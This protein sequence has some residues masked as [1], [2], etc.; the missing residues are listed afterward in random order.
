MSIIGSLPFILT[1][2]QVA[3]ATQVMADFNTIIAEVNAGAVP[4]SALPLAVASGG[5]GT[6]TLT[7]NAVLLGN[8]VGVVQEVAAGTNGNLL[9]DN[10]TIWESTTALTGAY[11]FSGAIA[12]SAAIVS[13]STI[14]FSGNTAAPAGA[15]V[16]SPAANTLCLSTNAVDRLCIGP[17]GG[18]YLQGA[19]GGDAGAGSL[20][21]A[22]IFQNG[23][24]VDAVKARA[25]YNG[26]TA[27]LVGNLNI[28]SV[29]KNATGDYTFNFTTA[30][31]DAAFSAV[32]SQSNV[33]GGA[34]VVSRA[35]GN[36][37]VN[38]FNTNTGILTD[39][40]VDLICSE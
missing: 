24:Q 38:T 4:E 36:V 19:T 26:S 1:N 5:T 18:V 2:G 16:H 3:D 30:F 21:F 22:T 31:A 12:F 15:G 14:A 13:S 29:T 23:K 8:N 34:C 20:N 10:G 28:A 39:V 33:S 35:A 11:T 9:M 17:T 37:R 27:T 7:A 40:V 6:N 25:Q 32:V